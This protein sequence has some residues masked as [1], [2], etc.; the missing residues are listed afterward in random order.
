M[1]ELTADDLWII[2]TALCCSIAAGILGCFL[3]L[4]RM[5]LLGDAISHAVLPGLALAF[6]FTGSRDPVAMMAGAMIAGVLTAYLTST[7]NRWGRIPEDAAMGV[8]FTSLF[9]VGVLL[10]NWVARDVDLDP[11]CV[12]YGLLEFVPFDTVLLGGYELP[13]SFVWLFSVL[14]IDAALIVI[15]FKGCHPFQ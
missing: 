11:G 7:L 5:S 8:V 12:L 2:A 3:V 10:V 15:F 1:F 4:R 6:V 14:V 13:R 9:A